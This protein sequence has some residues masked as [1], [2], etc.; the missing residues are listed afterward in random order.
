[1]PHPDHADR[2]DLHGAD[3]LAGK[4]L[5]D[6]E[7]YYIQR[8]LELTE[9]KREEAAQLLGIG[10]RTLYRKIKEFGLV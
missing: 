9:G 4:P 1:M 10:E 8:A 2:S 7:R 6:V 3:S 5:V